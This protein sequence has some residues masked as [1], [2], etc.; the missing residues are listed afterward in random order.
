[1]DVTKAPPLDSTVSRSGAGPTP[2][3]SGAL[4]SP[5]D[6][7]TP[8]DRLDIQPLDLTAALQILIAEVRSVMELAPDSPMMQSTAQASRAL[9]HLFLQAVPDDLSNPPTWTAE[10]TRVEVAFQAAIDRAVDTV[11]AWRD[12]PQFVVDAAKD[13]RALVATQM[14]DDPPSPNWLRPEWVGLAPMVQRFWRRRRLARRG[15]TDPDLRLS[16]S[17]DATDANGPTDDTPPRSDR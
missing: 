11:A 15:L 17:G 14:S 6:V 13:T 7:V 1:M 2:P 4:P 3:Q 5:N 8:A 16:R 12:V 9:I 10:S